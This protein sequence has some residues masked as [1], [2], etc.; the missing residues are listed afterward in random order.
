MACRKR[1][2]GCRTGCLRREMVRD[3]Q[4]E[5][6]RQE[7]AM[8]EATGLKPG[9]VEEYLSNNDLITFKQ[10]LTARRRTA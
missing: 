3:Y 6:E 9:E 5:R 8:E 1:M 4:Q 7:T 2:L 10:W